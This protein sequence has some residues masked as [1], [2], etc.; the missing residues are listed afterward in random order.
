MEDSKPPNLRHGSWVSEG[1]EMAFFCEFELG[2]DNL[3][4]TVSVSKSCL[5]C[6]G[7]GGF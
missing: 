4:A 1:S 3:R 6:L 7:S 5:F 2:W